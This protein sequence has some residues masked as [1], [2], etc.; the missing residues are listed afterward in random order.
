MLTEGKSVTLK[1]V[2]L[3]IDEL[4]LL[5]KH[6]K[7][8]L[9]IARVEL[10][11][12]KFSPPTISY[13]G[14]VSEVKIGA[15]K[16][17]GGSRAKS[18]VIG[19]EQTMPFYRFMGPTPHEPIVS[20]DVFDVKVP[21]PKAVREVYGD[22][23]DDPVEWAKV[24]VDKFNAEMVQVHLVSTDP[25]VKDAAP[26]EAVKTIEDVLQAI[27]VPIAVGA[28]GH[29]QKDPLVLEKAAEVAEGERIVLNSA[30]LDTDYKRIGEAAKKHGHVV[31]SFTQLDLNM[32]KRIN[33][34]LLAIG[35]GKDSIVMDPCTAALGYGLEYTFSIMER[36]RL[37]ALL[38]D[39]EL[40]MPLASGTSNSWAAREA[41]QDKPELGPREVRGPLWEAT[42]A[43][44]LL[45]AGCDFFM[46]LHPTTA[47]II[48]SAVSALTTEAK[49]E[50]T[51][52]LE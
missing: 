33:R 22:A 3:G 15:V 41:W 52:W 42:T 20:F 16:G 5:V 47:K 46:V 28:P 12:L 19:G 29:P 11:K 7:A 45:T 27:D 1:S 38:G 44:A 14:S 2:D 21:L 32:Q 13:K 43:L 9:P 50:A 17:E 36:I 6:P 37:A 31:V 30:R 34:E 35:L 24:C 23:I 25:N 48:E 26:S 39:E 4:N 51:K 40:Q 49:V 18:L 10:P 8:L